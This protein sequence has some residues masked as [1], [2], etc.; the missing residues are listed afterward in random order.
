MPRGKPDMSNA[1]P[2]AYNSQGNG[3]RQNVSLLNE[4]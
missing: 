3:Y 1:K 4:V 2:Y